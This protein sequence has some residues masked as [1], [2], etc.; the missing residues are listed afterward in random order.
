MLTS[1]KNK[2]KCADNFAPV[3]TLYF[4]HMVKCPGTIDIHFGQRSMR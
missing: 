4:R 3:F 2:P 1:H